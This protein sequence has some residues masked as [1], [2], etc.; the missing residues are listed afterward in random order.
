M[1]SQGLTTKEV[2]FVEEL[3]KACALKLSKLECY[4][5]EAQDGQLQDICRR[6]IQH[7]SRQIDELLS[8]LH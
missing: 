4:E 3:I 1:E 2:G 6:G 8:L 7:H 5:R